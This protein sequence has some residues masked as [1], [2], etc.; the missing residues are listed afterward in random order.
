MGNEGYAAWMPVNGKRELFYNESKALRPDL[1]VIDTDGCCWTHGSKASQ[2]SHVED[3]IDSYSVCGNDLPASDSA[4]ACDRDTNDFMTAFFGGPMGGTPFIYPLMYDMQAGG[5]CNL[6]S[7]PGSCV[8]P[9]PLI[10]HEMGNY[11]SYPNLTAQI[12]A[13]NNSRTMIATGAMQTLKSMVEQ[14]LDGELNDW[15]I[16]SSEHAH[17]SWKITVEAL[18]L[19]PYV[20][21]HQWWLFEDWAPIHNGLVNFVGFEPKGNALAASKIRRF[22]GPVVVLLKN[23]TLWQPSPTGDAG[24]FGYISGELIEPEIVV[25][26][27]APSALQD[28]VLSWHVHNVADQQQLH[29]GTLTASNIGQGTVESVGNASFVLP[30]TTKPRQFS[31]SVSLVCAGTT[32]PKPQT[33]SWTAWVFPP[34]S[35]TASQAVPIFASAPL[36][37]Q[38]TSL[39]TIPHIQPWPCHGASCKLPTKAVYL[40]SQGSLALPELSTAIS[41]GASAVLISWDHHNDPA[42]SSMMPPIQPRAVIFHSPSWVETA[43]TPASIMVNKAPTTPTDFVALASPSGWADAGWFEAFGP[44]KGKCNWRWGMMWDVSTGTGNLPPEPLAPLSP[45]PPCFFYHNTSCP[46]PRCRVDSSGH[47]G[48]TPRPPPPPAPPPPPPTPTPGPHNETWIGPVKS[49]YGDKDCPNQGCHGGSTAPLSVGQCEVLCDLSKG[50]NAFNYNSG[51]CCL[52]ACPPGKL[53]GPPHNNGCCAYYRSSNATLSGVE[54]P[55]LKQPAANT[56]I[57]VWL[58]VVLNGAISN[59][60][61]VFESKVGQGSLIVSGLDLD[62]NMCNATASLPPS[63]RRALQPS[64]F[65]RWVSKA[66]VDAAVERVTRRHGGG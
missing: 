7:N 15:V 16:T 43:S 54:S 27:Y 50:C 28:C 63:E 51:G 37:P 66:L 5:A 36:L 55:R 42:N 32:L 65:S 3:V 25:S 53:D 38:L 61:S 17:L 57:N 13:Y 48:N 10:S 8:P 59:M 52:R 39:G 30:T 49:T 12:L 44:L 34:K 14:N 47:C 64:M 29:N 62:L 18:R 40:V 41:A 6:T 58:R 21:G 23:Q 33:N 45:P 35:P 46:G 26:N 31:L 2:Y 20:T 56:S 19:Q 22:V 11:G 9:K 24:T 4:G 60:A 1:F